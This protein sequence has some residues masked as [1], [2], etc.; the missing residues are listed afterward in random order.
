MFPPQK[1][2]KKLALMLVQ[3]DDEQMRLTMFNLSLRVILALNIRKFVFLCYDNTSLQE[4]IV[5]A[6]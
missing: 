6:N 3:T 2:L 4:S 1:M 5:T